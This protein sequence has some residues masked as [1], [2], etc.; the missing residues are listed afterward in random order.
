MSYSSIVLD[1]FFNPRHIGVLPSPS[2]IG[3]IGTPGEGNFFQ[4]YI[5][6]ERNIIIDAKVRCF[7]CPVAVAAADMAAERLHLMTIEEAQNFS[8]GDLAKA[9]G[10]VPE[11]KMSRC[12]WV[13]QAVRKA[14]DDYLVNSIS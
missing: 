11:E 3:E 9:L 2:G 12:R 5:T 14:I 13:I 6:I 4:F 7:T 8:P 1:H 10:G